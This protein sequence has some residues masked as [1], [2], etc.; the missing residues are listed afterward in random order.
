M[1]G[2]AGEIDLG[3]QS[4]RTESLT[5]TKQASGSLVDERDYNKVPGVNPV[6]AQLRFTPEQVYNNIM[7]CIRFL[8]QQFVRNYYCR[9]V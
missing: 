9:T 6:Q 3:S 7:T 1:E 4:R 2:V 8:R 5:I